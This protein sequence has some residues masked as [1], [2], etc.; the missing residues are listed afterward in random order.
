MI[1]RAT[2]FLRMQSMGTFYTAAIATLATGYTYGTMST[3][4]DVSDVNRIALQGS[5]TCASNA[6][7]TTDFVIIAQVNGLWDTIGN[8][9]YTLSVMQPGAGTGGTPARLTEILSVDGI[10][11]IRIAFMENVGGNGAT[12]MATITNVNITYARSIKGIKMHIRQL[13][14]A[15]AGTVT[16]TPVRIDW[17]RNINGGVP[18]TI[19]HEVG[20]LVNVRIEIQGAIA[21]QAEVALGTANFE[22][23]EGGIFTKE[24]AYGVVMVYPYMR[25]VITRHTRGTVSIRLAES[26]GLMP[27]TPHD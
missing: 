12:S 10:E 13:L 20:P 18:I 6:T 24:G 5:C 2:K 27:I 26:V 17:T 23:I 3:A 1:P 9:F 15:T 16:G 22:T 21:T 4:I 25:A 11:A 8:P 14:S 7:S 19:S